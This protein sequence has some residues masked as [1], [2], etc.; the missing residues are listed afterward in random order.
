MCIFLMKLTI[1]LHI[2]FYF[3]CRYNKL[4]HQV[5]TIVTK[6]KDMEEDEF[7][8]QMSNQLTNKLYSMGL[9][10]SKRLKTIS[11]LS[12]GAFAKRRL[13]VFII[14]SK[15]FNGPLSTAGKLI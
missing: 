4:I 6:L 2:T 15:M 5:R 12:A 11:R 13:P 1:C 7:R 9:I 3:I 14:K 10:E 8:I